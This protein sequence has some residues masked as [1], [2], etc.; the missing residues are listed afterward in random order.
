MPGTLIPPWYIPDL[1][2]CNDLTVVSVVWGFSLGLA[3]FGLIRAGNQTFHQWKRTRRVTAYMVFIWLELV[4]STVLGGIGWAHVYGTIPPSFEFFFFIIIM[5][6]FQIHCIMQIIINRI[7]LLAISPTTVR[8]L[9]WGIFGILLVINISVGS[10]WIP[11]RL[12]IN[13]T[14]IHVNNIYDRL[15]KAIF[16]VIDVCLN[17]YFIYLVR[18]SL[19]E[20]GLTKYVLLYRFNQVMI[21]LSLT[22]DILIIATMSL[23]NN[24]LYVIFHPLAYLVKLHIELSMAELIGKIVKATGSDLTCV[25]VCHQNNIHPFAFSPNLYSSAPAEV[26]PVASIR[27]RMRRTWPRWPA[28]LRMIRRGDD[29]GDEEHIT[30]AGRDSIRL[31]MM[32]RTEEFGG[33]THSCPTLPARKDSGFA[34]TSMASLAGQSSSG[35]SITDHTD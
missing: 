21:V 9:R 16:A 32:P 4:A 30:T 3:V 13:P 34:T 11:A 22:M 24:F 10:V 8:R 15:E 26:R 25:C 1:P 23:S 35:K 18:S 19:I 33:R 27:G 28:P 17:L 2:S 5:W 29:G 14:W 31:R 12:Q 20:Y 7:A 6:I